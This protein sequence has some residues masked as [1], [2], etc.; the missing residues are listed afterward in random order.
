[1]TTMNNGM[2]MTEAQEE[3]FGLALA[4]CTSKEDYANVAAEF[5]VDFDELMADLESQHQDEAYDAWK[6]EQCC[7]A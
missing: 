5:D 2:E 7:R 4:D 6:D 3:E 1:M